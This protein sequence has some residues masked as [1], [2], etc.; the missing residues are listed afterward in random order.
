MKH[1]YIKKSSGALE[2]F[3]IEKF[4]RSLSKAGVPNDIIEKLS[5][6]ILN[7]P[8]IHTT[9]D[10]YAFAY[11]YLKKTQKP[12]AARYN[13]KHALY[14]LGPEGF[15]FERFVAQL[16]RWQNYT[17]LL[18]QI[19]AG[20]CVEHEI[21]IVLARDGKRKM[22]ECKFH[23]MPGTKSDVKVPLYIQARYEDIRTSSMKNSDSFDKAVLITNTQFTSQAIHYGECVGIE[24]I[25]WAYPE[26]GNI[27]DLITMLNAHPIT[28]LSELT[29]HQKKRLIER[30]IFFCK[31]LIAKPHLLAEFGLDKSH[32]ISI[33]N[34]CEA[35]EKKTH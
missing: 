11:D 10:I 29:P 27:A 31:D 19:L 6:E 28:V 8:G 20:K 14:E 4:R 15:A 18:D 7:T 32:I 9:R 35:L 13:L 23:N 12:L 26:K 5:N 30:G 1:S 21:D 22:V 33:H 3:S 17:T 25:G 34:E 16:F 24:L 2:P